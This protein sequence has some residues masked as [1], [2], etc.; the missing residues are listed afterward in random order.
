MNVNLTNATDSPKATKVLGEVGDVSVE[1][2]EVG[3]SEEGFFSKLASF[4]L[5]EN[6]PSK[7]LQI[8]K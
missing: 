4:I 7:P 8:V 5:G 3:E 6:K 2:S 1:S